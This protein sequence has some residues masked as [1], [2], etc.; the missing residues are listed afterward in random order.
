MRQLVAVVGPTGSGK[1]ALAIDLAEHL[2]SEII[3][4]DSMQFYRGMEI[5]TAAPTDEELKRVKH[6]FVGHL[7][8]SDEMS[9][10]N[11]LLASRAVMEDL[12][13]RGKTAVVVGGS[14]LY[15]QALIDGLFDGPGKVPAIRERL[16][17]E[18][19]EKGPEALH[20]RLESVD[21]EYAA[22]I[23][24]TDLRRIVRALEVHEV[25]GRPLSEL[26]REHRERTKSLDAVQVALDWPR[27]LLY[28]RINARVDAMLEAGFVEEVERIIEEG[29]GEDLI[30]HRSIGYR[31]IAAHLRGESS[32]E[33]AVEL[34]KMYSRRYAK[35]QLTWFRG[36][37]RIHWLDAAE[38]RLFHLEQIANLLE[39]SNILP[40]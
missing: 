7:T 21:P 22:R 34:M 19:E 16:E 9:A 28:E 4:A 20:L 3:S 23:E 27:K 8:P 33:E 40:A 38:D 15:I 10:G 26:H 39:I 29:Y 6:H 1:T 30:R 32:L 14:G 18:A 24:K 37:S 31:E 17:A 35:R 2:G 25:T 36:D 12:N 11:Y 13:A 5:G